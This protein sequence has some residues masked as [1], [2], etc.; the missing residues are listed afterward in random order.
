MI[1]ALVAQRAVTSIETGSKPEVLHQAALQV[2]VIAVLHPCQKTK[3]GISPAKAGRAH[4]LDPID[5][6]HHVMRKNN[7]KY[8]QLRFPIVGD[9]LSSYGVFF[10]GFKSHEKG[11]I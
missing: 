6:A 10:L 9:D 2:P 4:L 7:K 1:L 3:Y 8:P 11:G 5:P